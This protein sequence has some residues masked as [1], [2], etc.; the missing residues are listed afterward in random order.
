MEDIYL[1]G[2]HRRE[3]CSDKVHLKSYFDQFSNELSIINSKTKGKIKSEMEI[4]Q[5][6]VP[7]ANQLSQE[8]FLS[9]GEDCRY[10]RLI[11]IGLEYSIV[12]FRLDAKTRQQSHRQSRIQFRHHN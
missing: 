3:W 6:F 10:C 9:L 8:E 7:Q 11:F 1:K 12:F 5:L 4:L 2:F